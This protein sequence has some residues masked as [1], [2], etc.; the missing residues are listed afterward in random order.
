VKVPVD[1]PP[2][3]RD[4]V[5]AN[6]LTVPVLL[7]SPTRIP[8]P[9]KVSHCLTTSNE[10]GVGESGNEPEH[11]SDDGDVGAV[12]LGQGAGVDDGPRR[13]Q[14]VTV[15]DEADGGVVG[16]TDLRSTRAGQRAGHRE[17]A[18]VVEL[19]AVGDC[20]AGAR[21][22]GVVSNDRAT[23]QVAAYHMVVGQG[24]DKFS[25]QAYSSFGRG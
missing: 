14:K 9:E 16:V 24:C 21:D 12:D 13:A 5:P 22:H 20:R 6:A 3:L 7:W 17:V 15:G 1:E 8:P 18:V 4:K 10:N 11:G 25:S 23:A 2:P 19:V